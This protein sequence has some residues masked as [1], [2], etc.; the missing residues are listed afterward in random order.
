MARLD[1][2]VD[3]VLGD[4]IEVRH[5][6]GPWVPRMAFI[7]FDVAGSSNQGFGIDEIDSLRTRTRLKIRQTHIP[8]PSTAVTIRA[9]GKLAGIWRL[10]G[11][12]PEQEGRYWLLDIQ[13]AST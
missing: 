2:S 5:G 6:V 12:I 10:S 8:T 11:D 9:T 3:D 13:K 4:S 1:D 7:Q